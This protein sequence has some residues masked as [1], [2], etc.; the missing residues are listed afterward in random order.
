MHPSPASEAWHAMRGLLTQGEGHRRMLAAC[1][2]SGLTPGL[3]KVCLH[4]STGEPRAM[5]DLA[6]HFACDA[7]YIT[8]VVDGLE[9]QGLAERRQHPS[10]RRIKTVVLTERGAEVVARMNEVL[11][12]PPAAF[13]A[14]SVAEQEQLRDLLE[15][16]VA[17]SATSAAVGAATR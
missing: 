2:L 12:E 4:L 7:S 9:Q 1:S 13:D 6:Q 3:M 14:L 15:R 16:L 5:R 8:S 10:D 11:D 17:A